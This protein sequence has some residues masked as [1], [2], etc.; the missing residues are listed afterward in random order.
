MYND[1]SGSYDALNLSQTCTEQI[2]EKRAKEIREVTLVNNVYRASIEIA[3]PATR[4]WYILLKHC[5][6]SNAIYPIIDYNINMSLSSFV[7]DVKTIY[8]KNKSL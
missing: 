2:N 1:E 6:D 5:N 7:L 8:N 4:N 3:E